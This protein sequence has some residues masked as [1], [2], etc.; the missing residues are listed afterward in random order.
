MYIQLYN[1]QSTNNTM[2]KSI[3][4]LNTVSA[5]LKQNCSVEE[6]E[7]TLLYNSNDI[8]NVNYIYIEDFKRYYFCKIETLQGNKYRLSCAVD[9]LESFK[10]DIKSLNIIISDTEKYLANNYLPSDIWINNV[11]AKTTIMNFPNGLLD[12]GEFILIT[13]GG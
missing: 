12:D 10:D 1:N 2:G 8:D 13:A 3:T 6:P 5:I 7:L 11:K 4:L 9:V